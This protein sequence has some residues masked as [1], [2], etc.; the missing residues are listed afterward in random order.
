MEM[1]TCRGCG[2][3]WPLEILQ[4]GMGL[5]PMCQKVRERQR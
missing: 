3:S 2:K 4:K 1:G 5:C